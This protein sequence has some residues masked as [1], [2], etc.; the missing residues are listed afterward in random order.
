MHSLA[1]HQKERNLISLLRAEV[2]ANEIQAYVLGVSDQLV[3]LQ[4]V[5]DFNLDGLLVIR[6]QDITDVRRTETDKFQ[7][8]LLAQ[9]GVENAVPFGLNLP[10]ADWK[11]V[12]THLASCYPL[13]IL[14][15]ELDP[16]PGFAIGRVL[17]ATATRVE[18]L[19]FSGAGKLCQ[20]PVR[21]K[22]ANLTSLQVNTN[23]ANFYQRHF[24]RNAA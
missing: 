3:A 4:Y 15:S 23:Y 1:L 7:Q 18:L 22:Y 13:M 12:I 21:L 11:S 10:L 24:E 20:K 14:E 6:Q 2:D 9:E 16:D 17:A 19:S 5:Y 8:K